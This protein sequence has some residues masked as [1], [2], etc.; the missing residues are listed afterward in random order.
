MRRA[1]AKTLA[2]TAGTV[3]ASALLG[4]TIAVL[5]NRARPG[6]ARFRAA[7][8]TPV[9]TSTAAVGS[10]GL[11]TFVASWNSYLWP[12]IVTDR[13]EMRAVQVALRYHMDADLGTRWSELMAASVLIVAPIVVLF[14][15]A[16]RQFV[17]G[18]TA[19][20]LKG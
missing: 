1:L 13:N 17:Q 10:L 19:F 15:V 8:F 7:F 6:G 2:F 16:A 5:L 14:L 18:L 11:R 9:V 20:G 12:L 4:L 3:P